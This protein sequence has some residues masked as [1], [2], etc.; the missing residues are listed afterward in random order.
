[1]KKVSYLYAFAGIAGMCLFSCQAGGE[2]SEAQATSQEESWTISETTALQRMT[3]SEVTKII[4]YQ[5]KTFHSTV[6]RTPDESLPIV[7][8]EQGDKF[9]DNRISL[10][11]T[12]EGKSIVNRTY[13]KED[14]APLVN[15]TFL[16]HSILE[17]LVY[18]DT[19]SQGMRFIA[20]LCYPQTDLYVP[21]RLTIT[22]DGKIAMEK[23]EQLE[24][25]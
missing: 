3:A 14:F 21:V 4:T 12:C 25:F 1:M 11:I 6:V 8:N 19:T 18:F 24:D 22:S 23:I 16:K 13:T 17:G 20:N 15:A 9:V 2:K 7:L 5:G 10:H